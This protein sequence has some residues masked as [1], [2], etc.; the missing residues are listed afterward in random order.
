VGLFYRKAFLKRLPFN[1]TYLETVCDV[2]GSVTA[3]TIQAD[4][5]PVP[6]YP[7]P[8]TA[9]GWYGPP[10]LVGVIG[11]PGSGPGGSNPASP[12]NWQVGGWLQISVSTAADIDTSV[13]NYDYSGV[14]PYTLFPYSA[15]TYNSN[16]FTFTLS[17][18]FNLG[19]SSH[20]SGRTPGWGNTVPG[21]VAPPVI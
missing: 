19:F 15:T 12:G 11:P 13:Y 21:L 4:P 10:W 17:T 6:Q 3:E 9:T 1:H 18:Q 16:S 2:N 7:N 8:P 20:S 5:G 14:S